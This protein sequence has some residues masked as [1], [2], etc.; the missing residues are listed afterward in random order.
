VDSIEQKKMAQ[1]SRVAPNP[2]KEEGGK[3]KL[4][5]APRASRPKK[6]EAIIRAG[7]LRCKITI[8][9]YEFASFMTS[10]ENNISLLHKTYVKKM[11]VGSDSVLIQ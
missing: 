2:P 8:L 10:I 6:C 11:E 3:D 4:L 9:I 7:L 1:P 5:W